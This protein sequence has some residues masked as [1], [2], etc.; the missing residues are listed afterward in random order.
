[1]RRPHSSATSHTAVVVKEPRSRLWPL[2][3]SAPVFITVRQR[4]PP[5]SARRAVG[6]CRCAHNPPAFCWG[7]LFMTVLSGPYKSITAGFPLFGRALVRVLECLNC[8]I[9][10]D[11]LNCRRRNGL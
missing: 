5:A 2:T 4:N 3:R 9:V 1:H 7:S 10:K 11:V 6:P 8:P